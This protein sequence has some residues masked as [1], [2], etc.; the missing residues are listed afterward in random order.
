MSFFQ[1]SFET[2]AAECEKTS[3]YTRGEYF[4]CI[5]D[6]SVYST[7]DAE[8]LKV[9]MFEFGKLNVFLQVLQ[10]HNRSIMFV[11]EDFV[12]S[13]Q[14]FQEHNKRSYILISHDSDYAVP[15]GLCGTSSETL[16]A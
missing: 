7:K 13:L 10:I 1:K 5:S 8:N 11:K 6:Y 16:L 9:L 12:C 15:F 14:L 4:R 3:F 2:R